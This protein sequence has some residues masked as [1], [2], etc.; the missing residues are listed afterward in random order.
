MIIYPSCF[1]WSQ[2]HIRFFSDRLKIH[3]SSSFFSSYRTG[4]SHYWP[5]QVVSLSHELSIKF[6]A[7]ARI[8]AFQCHSSYILDLSSTS[9]LIYLK[10]VN[11]LELRWNLDDNQ[12]HE[13][14]NRI[15]LTLV[16]S[17]RSR[18]TYLLELSDIYRATLK[19]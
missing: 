11:G 19:V 7:P 8:P 6:H 18:P 1:L 16:Y 4:V 12:F 14:W 9:Y 5:D 10:K 13:Y 2:P 17:D 15:H 3:P